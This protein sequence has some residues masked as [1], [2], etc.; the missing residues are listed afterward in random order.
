[1]GRV[2]VSSN[3]TLG[4]QWDR[5][6]RV[7]VII[8]IVMSFAALAL[9]YMLQEEHGVGADSVSWLPAEAGNITFL[10]APITHKTAEFDI[11]Q[12]AFERW[13]HGQGRSLR[14]LGERETQRVSRCLLL[15]ETRGIIPGPNEPNEVEETIYRMEQVTK[16]FGEGDLFYEERWSNGGGYSIGYDVNEQRGYYEY[17]HH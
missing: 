15:L 6:T 10:S 3:M 1:M 11:V 14:E 7:V 2:K 9:W 4:R 17:R 8:L 12:G 16:D 5:M 13:C